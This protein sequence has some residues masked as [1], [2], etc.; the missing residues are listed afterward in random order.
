MK[1]N[2]S[3]ILSIFPVLSVIA[4]LYLLLQNPEDLSG[5]WSGSASRHL[6]TYTLSFFSLL[7]LFKKTIKQ[8][9]KLYFTCL[10]L[11]LVCVGAG[12][13]SSFATL[14]FLISCYILGKLLITN[15][16]GDKIESYNFV[17]SIIIGL[18][19]IVLMNS[20]FLLL[21]INTWIFHFLLLTAPF[22]IYYLK[23]KSFSH[24]I[25]HFRSA[26]RNL[27]L[28]LD[29]ANEKI[30]YGFLFLL[31]YIATFSFFPTIGHDEN[32]VHLSIWTQ[33]SKNYA[34]NIDPTAQIWSAAPNTVSLLHGVISLLAGMDAKGS[35][36]IT[37]LLFTTLGVFQILKHIGID[38][39]NNLTL[40]TLFVSTPIIAFLLTGLQTDLFIGLMLLAVVISTML[41]SDNFLPHAVGALMAGSLA[42][43]AK[44]TGILIAGP[45]L[46]AL[47]FI[48]IKK[49]TFIR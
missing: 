7:F 14:F 26:A 27:H 20:F 36:N 19:C 39:N 42:F 38:K 11:L 24:E 13:R 46:I 48:F 12:A 10:L 34:F 37:I 44:F 35:L 25:I 17:P 8:G 41:S 15:I 33:L 18:A 28:F 49:T 29:S 43:S 32:A 22:L 45:A 47:V 4:V 31:T 2:I 5:T 40:C 23:Y 6:L 1:I 16:T 9:Y 21:P 3:A 30:L